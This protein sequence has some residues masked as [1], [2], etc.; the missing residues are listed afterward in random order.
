MKNPF[1]WS[2]IIVSPL[3]KRQISKDITTHFTQKVIIWLGFRREE[4]LNELKNKLIFEQ[5]L[6]TKQITINKK[7]TKASF[8]LTQMIINKSQPFSEG[9]F[10]KECILEA[11]EVICPEKR[12]LFADISL[13]RN[14]V[15]RR[16]EKLSENLK[17]KLVDLSKEF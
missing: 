15:M 16:T 5:N 10:I 3:L 6:F 2:A 12:H 11:C 9:E 13:S 4:K 1:V 17:Q 7:S 14:I 8:R